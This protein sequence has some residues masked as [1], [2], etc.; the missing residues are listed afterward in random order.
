MPLCRAQCTHAA[1]AL[2][3]RRGCNDA[4][5]QSVSLK[6]DGTDGTATTDGT[7][8]TGHKSYRFAA[9]INLRALTQT[10]HARG[11]SHMQ[12]NNVRHYSYISIDVPFGLYNCCSVPSVLAVPSPTGQT[13]RRSPVSRLLGRPVCPVMF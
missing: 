8:A 9:K 1:G 2:A 3:N 10:S 7:G 13:G 5:L 12:A 6:H 4:A 11:S